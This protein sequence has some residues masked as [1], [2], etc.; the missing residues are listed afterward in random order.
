MLLQ[1]LVEY[2]DIS[3]ILAVVKA[4]IGAVIIYHTNHKI[5]LM[6]QPPTNSATADSTSPSSSPSAS[7]FW[8]KWDVQ[9]ILAERTTFSGDHE[10]LV[11][12]KTSWIPKSDMLAAPDGPVMSRFVA[13]SKVLFRNS[14]VRDMRIIM[15][16]SPGSVF[17]D[18]CTEIACLDKE[19]CQD[20][21][22]RR[23]KTKF[24]SAIA[25]RT[26]P[27]TRGH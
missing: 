10:L 23:V 18:D 2:G 27:K 5:I 7:Y 14:V 15:P 3:R 9:E 13:A 26:R 22:E 16:V 4:Q 21:E 1:F 6:A 25:D 8:P 11:V 12:W 20:V 24:E 17:D 19:N